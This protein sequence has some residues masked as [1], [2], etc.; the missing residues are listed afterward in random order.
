MSDWLG[1]EKLSLAR[2]RPQNRIPTV[3]IRL[4]E[5]VRKHGPLAPVV[6]RR[7]GDGYEI[8][9]NAETWL[10]AQRLGKR[11]VPVEILPEISDEEAAEI[12]DGSYSPS[13]RDDP[14]AEAR[15]LAD[16]LDELGGRSKRGSIQ[17]LAGIT[18]LSRTY[19]SHALRL[20]RLP[21]QIQDFL[22]SGQISVG[23]A[24]LLVAIDSQE[25]QWA[26]ASQVATEGLSVR[27]TE[28]L[29]RAAREGKPEPEA[30]AD[31]GEDPD[32]IRLERLLT[33]ILGAATSIDASA[34]KVVIDYA[35][36]LD[37]LDGVLQ[38]I[39]VQDF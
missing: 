1:I 10:A 2:M 15:F 5:T 8:L 21:L 24:K 13:D 17:R 3:S 7:V 32:L 23:H 19:I 33:G 31:A 38:R 14:L 4:L 28:L 39:G 29:V 11:Q 26:L 12:V 9:T 16:R 25:D 30:V 34:G 36:D 35:R 37:V 27:E 18:G 20:L 22:R 6:V